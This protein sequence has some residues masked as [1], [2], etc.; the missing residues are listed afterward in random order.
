VSCLIAEDLRECFFLQRW[1]RTEDN[2]RREVFGPLERHRCRWEAGARRIQTADGR[3]I[4]AQGTL[5]TT[6]RVG[7]E[8]LRKLRLWLPGDDPT[9][10]GLSRQ[11]TQVYPRTDLETGAF[12]HSELVL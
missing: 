12:D 6:A 2:G 1:L 4:V 8:E 3:T 10:V 5:F 11:A 9:D 7:Q